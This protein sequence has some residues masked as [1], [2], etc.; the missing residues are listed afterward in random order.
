MFP[1]YDHDA[2]WFPTLSSTTC[3][4][5]RRILSMKTLVCRT[6]TLVMLFLVLLLCQQ[7]PSRHPKGSSAHRKQTAFFAIDDES[8]TVNRPKAFLFSERARAS[9]AL[10]SVDLHD[11][12]VSLG[13]A[14]DLTLSRETPT[15]FSLRLL[16]TQTHSSAT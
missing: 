4:S 7:T 12:A 11:P 13:N 3:C 9:G 1:K 5:D 14:R 10:V 8:T 16:D 6:L 15:A 2:G